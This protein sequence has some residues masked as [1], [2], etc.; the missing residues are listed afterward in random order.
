[1]SFYSM[2]NYNQMPYMYGSYNRYHN[3]YMYG[4]GLFPP[5]QSYYYGSHGSMGSG[6]YGGYGSN[7]PYSSSYYGGGYRQQG[8]FRNMMN[9]LRYGNSY[10]YPEMG[11]MGTGS[12]RWPYERDFGSTKCVW[13]RNGIY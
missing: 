12:G 11:Y 1:M 9:R 5:Q 4:G 3:P 6:S 2:Y 7:Y 10:Y 8:L 13:K